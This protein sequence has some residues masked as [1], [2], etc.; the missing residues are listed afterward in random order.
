LYAPPQVT[1]DM[2]NLLVTFELQIKT[3]MANQNIDGIDFLYTI[4]EDPPIFFSSSMVLALH[5]VYIYSF[6]RRTPTNCPTTLYF[7]LHYTL[8]LNVEILVDIFIANKM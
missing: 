5:M 4:D 6:I 7:S 1:A 2:S 8:N 3:F